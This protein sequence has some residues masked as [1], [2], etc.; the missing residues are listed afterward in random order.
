[1]S[2][3]RLRR[4]Q[5][6]GPLRREAAVRAPAARHGRKPVLEEDE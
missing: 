6:Q 3:E 2:D 5:G 4:E 1:M